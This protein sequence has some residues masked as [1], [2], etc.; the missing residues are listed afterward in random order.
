MKVSLIL[1]TLNR[2][3]DLA[4]FLDS[5]L[6]QT[7][8][9]FELIVIDQNKGDEIK[10]IL[11]NYL[12]KIDIKYIKSDILGISVNRNKGLI[13]RTG[14]IIGFPD[15]DCSY[16]PDTLEKVV[17]YLKDKKKHIYSCRTLEKVKNY[18]TGIMLDYNTNITV[19]NADLT[20]K[21]ITFFVNIEGQDIYLFDKKLGVGALFGSGEETDYVLNLLHKGYVG[22]YFANDIIY[23]PAKKGNYEDLERAYNY[24]RGY[25]ALCKKEVVVRKNYMYFFKFLNKVFR[26]IAGVMFSKHKDYHGEVLKGRISGYFGYKN[27]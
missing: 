15:D 7:Y 14:E 4:V 22:E 21:S 23:H 11:D 24:A 13:C 25:G 6:E 19:S 5:L 10:E 12:N 3:D 9:D 18:G 8:K 27:D 26:S 17:S 20:V 2:T 1:P 16:A